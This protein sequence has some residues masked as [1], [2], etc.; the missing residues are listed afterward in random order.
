MQ[1]MIK[2][3]N[4]LANKAKIE[5]LNDA[6]KSEQASLRAQYLEKFRSG[7]NSQLMN[8]KVVDIDGNDVTPE[9]LKK[10]QK[11]NKK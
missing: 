1:D 11:E 2:R 8:L 3:I 5:E 9:K 7:F 6:E 4:E 10:A